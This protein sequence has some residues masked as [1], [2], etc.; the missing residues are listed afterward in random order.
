VDA[1]DEL[2]HR[3]GN[4]RHVSEDD[5]IEKVERSKEKWGE[6]EVH[7]IAGEIALRSTSLSLWQTKEGH[8]IGKR[9]EPQC[10]V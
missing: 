1:N 7:R 4:V 9:L 8:R 5:A 2:A 6:A 10:G 3:A